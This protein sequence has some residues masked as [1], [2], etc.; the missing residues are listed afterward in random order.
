MKFEGKHIKQFIDYCRHMF[1]GNN[2]ELVNVKELETNYHDKTPIWWYTYQCFLYPMLNRA[3][4]LM[5]VDMIIKISFFISDLHHHIEQ[6]HSKQFNDDHSCIS[7]TVYRGQR[8][9]KTDFNQPTKTKGG[10]L[11]FNTLLFTSKNRAVSLDFA[12][13]TVRKN[14]LV[15]ILFVMMIDPSRS[16]APFAS[17]TNVSFYENVEDEILFS[18]HTVF[19][20]GDIKPMDENNRL[21]QVNL[22]LTSD[23]DKDL[24]VLTDRIR[25]GAFPDAIEWDRL[26][27]F[28]FRMGQFHKAQQMYEVLLEQATNEFEKGFMYSEIGW[29][30]ERQGKYKEAIIFLTKSLEILQQTLPPYHPTLPSCYTNMGVAYSSMGEYSNALL[31]HEKALKIRQQTLCPNHPSLAVSY[32]GVGTMYCK[33]NEYSKALPFFER[34]LDIGQ[35]SLPSNHPE[36]LGYRKNLCLAKKNL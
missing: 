27:L 31:S 9:S 20:I 25:K 21:F 16:T 4:Q 34:A 15:G 8:L 24:C 26:G 36:L 6:L 7:F 32:N 5:E 28:L 17:I 29:A 10:L 12:R 3:L 22:M 14:D 1:A 11:F 33:L 13:P 30:K 19:C 35:C 18:M 23:N 2:K